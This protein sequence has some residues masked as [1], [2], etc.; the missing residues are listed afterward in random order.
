[1]VDTSRGQIFISHTHADRAL[2][3]ALTTLVKTIFGDQV[4][5]NFIR[6]ALGADGAAFERWRSALR[7]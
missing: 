4:V 5:V 2:A 6:E 3:E 1:M 7:A